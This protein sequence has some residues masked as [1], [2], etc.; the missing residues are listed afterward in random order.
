MSNARAN[1]WVIAGVGMVY[2]RA[3]VARN[4]HPLILPMLFEFHRVIILQLWVLCKVLRRSLIFP[5]DWLPILLM[6]V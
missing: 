1:E 6:L 2:A 3:A 4:E 5:K